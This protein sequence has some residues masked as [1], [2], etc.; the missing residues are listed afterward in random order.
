MYS[1]RLH[2]C[3]RFAIPPVP[4]FRVVHGNS[5]DIVLLLLAG[6]WMRKFG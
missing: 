5:V 3:R 2:L 6:R 4:G 1:F